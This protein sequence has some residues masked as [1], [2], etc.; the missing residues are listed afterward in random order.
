MRVREQSSLDYYHDGARKV[1]LWAM[2]VDPEE[3][4]GNVQQ[5]SLQMSREVLEAWMADIRDDR[6]VAAAHERSLDREDYRN[7]YYVRK[8]FETA[9]GVIENLRV[10]RCRKRKI[11]DEVRA[12]MERAKGAVERKVVDMFLK[13]VST[14]EVGGLLEGLIG[15]SMSAAKVS[16]LT[17]RLDEEVRRYHRSPLE[18]RY[19]YLFFD[20]IYLKSRTVPRM[21]KNMPQAR[22]RVVLAAYGVTWNGVKELIAFR[23]ESSEAKDGWRRFFLGLQQRGLTGEKAQLVVTDGGKGLI[24]AVA[25]CFPQALHQRC[26]FHKLSNVMAKV[27]VK[28]RKACLMGLRAV[29]DAPSRAAAEKAYARWAKRWCR[30]EPDAVR[31]VE[32]DLDALLVFY[33]VPP[34]HRKMVRTTNAIE[35]CFREVRRRTRSIGCFINDAS[36]ERILYGLF[37][38]MNQRRAGKVCKEFKAAMVAA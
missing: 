11:I 7:G 20:G 23:L 15:V 37:R 38:F 3:F 5:S 9:I 21:F 31:C 36:V 26:W 25:D 13:G 10:P 19:R 29:Y 8:G 27:R 2:M 35:R 28:N 12:T 24:E 30:E 34:A 6:V 16:R 22:R 32:R 4:F 1:K 18:D 33:G 14:R 17:Q